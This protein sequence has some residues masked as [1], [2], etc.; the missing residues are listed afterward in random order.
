[1]EL[2]RELLLTI[3]ALVLVN[4]LLA[5]G[6]IGLFARMGPAIERILQ[7]NVHSIDSVEEMLAELAYA[8]SAPLSSEAR[9]RVDRALENAKL[10]VTEEEERP[11]LEALARAL[12]SAMEG[13]TDGRRQAVA[14]ARQLIHINRIAMREVDDE[15]RRLG[16]AGAWA[17]VFV[18]F[19]SFLL[20]VFVVLRLQKRFVRPL[21][22]LH[23]VLQV[24]HEGDRLRRCR[25]ADAPREVIQVTQAV[26][27]LLDERLGRMNGN[28]S[29]NSA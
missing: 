4:L 17:A 15:A 8:G 1:M 2:R 10:N 28:C 25:L 9:T 7:E 11:V 5:F 3:G 16:V 22:D 29:T 19:L 14:S 12:P 18:G 13:E 26:N 27:R 20:S 23:Q 6:A 24:A 21:V